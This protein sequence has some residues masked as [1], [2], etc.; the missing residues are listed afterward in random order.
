M[1]VRLQSGINRESVLPALAILILAAASC[2]RVW[3][4]SGTMWD[5]NAWLMSAYATH[6]LQGFLNTGFFEMR[7]VP[8][9]IVLYPLFWLYKNTNLYYVVWHSLN[10]VT[11]IGAPLILYATC[12]RLFGNQRLLAFLIA[13]TLAVISL[14][15][16]LPYASA[17]NYRIGLLLGIISFYF[18]VRSVDIAC[19]QPDYGFCRL[20]RFYRSG[21][22]AGA[23]AICSDHV[24]IASTN[25]NEGYDADKDCA[26][27][28]ASVYCRLCALCDIQTCL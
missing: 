7:R 5:D 24:S 2:V 11:Q 20:H 23:R 1:I 16:T 4:I 19:C 26:S 3:T 17:V 22:D 13:A 12:L 10:M 8:L 6:D 9:G 21:D 25:W 14:D 15:Q 28:M 18:T 27:P